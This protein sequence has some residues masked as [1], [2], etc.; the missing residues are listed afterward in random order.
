ME[1]SHD[2]APSCWLTR[3]HIAGLWTAWASVPSPLWLH[4]CSADVNGDLYLSLFQMC[5]N[6]VIGVLLLDESELMKGSCSG[7]GMPSPPFLAIKASRSLSITESLSTSQMQ[8][9][10]DS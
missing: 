7:C 3:W 1:V 5:T 4:H 8:S 2:K 6:R 10:S 9:R